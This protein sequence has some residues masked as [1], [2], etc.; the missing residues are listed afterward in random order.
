L[1]ALIAVGFA[2]FLQGLATSGGPVRPALEKSTPLPVRAVEPL[3]STA[4]SLS[5]PLGR[6]FVEVSDAS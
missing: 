4:T 6:S 3:G 2:V 1:I 5:Q